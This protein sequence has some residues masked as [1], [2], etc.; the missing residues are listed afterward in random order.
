MDDRK[1]SMWERWLEDRLDAALDDATAID[2]TRTGATAMIACQVVWMNGAVA[3]GPVSRAG[4]PGLYKMLVEG[5]DQNGRGRV[6]DR[7]FSA[8]TV[9]FIDVPKEL[10]V[11]EKSRLYVPE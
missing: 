2:P 8:E 4:T 1:I 3:S 10:P 11:I 9:M 6:L 7:Y 5:K